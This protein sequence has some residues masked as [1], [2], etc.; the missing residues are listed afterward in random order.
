MTSTEKLQSL[1]I[2]L[3]KKQH[4][5][6][7]CISEYNELKRD[8]ELFELLQNTYTFI[9]KTNKGQLLYHL[10][11]NLS[12]QLC[13]CGKQRKFHK[14][15]KGYFKTCNDKECI[16]KERLQSIKETTIEK[17]G[18]EHTSQ[19][20]STKDKQK[21]TMLDRYGSTHN[22]SG[23][24][25]EK[26]YQNNI[27]KYGVKH[28]LQRGD[29]QEK[30][31]NTMIE[32]FGTLNMLH[33]DKAKKTNLEKYG[34]EN[35][36]KSKEVSDK[37]SVSLKE[38]FINRQIEKLVKWNIIIEKYDPEKQYYHV[39]CNKCKSNI[40]IAG[41]SLNSKLRSDV[42]PCTVCNPYIPSYVSKKEIEVADY[43]K[44][45]GF[46]VQ[47]SVK[48]IV[49]NSE[50]DIYIDDKKIGFEFNGLYWHSEIEK[51]E[52]YHINKTMK[53]LEKDVKIYHIW[54]DSWD[55]KREIVKS[56]IKSI[57]G[58]SEKLDARKCKMKFISS[59]ESK[60]FLDNNHLDGNVNAKVRIGLFYKDELVSVMTFSKA[61]FDRNDDW[62]LL[63][64]ANKLGINVR[65]AASKI[66]KLFI[67]SQSPKNVI[68]Y[69][70]IDWTPS[71]KN[72]VYSTIGFEK[73]DMTAPGVY[74]IV[75]GLRNNRQAY[76]KHKLVEQGEDPD[77]SAIEIMHEKGYYRAWDCGN[78]KFKI[79]I[80]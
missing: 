52:Y 24:I 8:K 9:D 26:T 6:M 25:R 15:D 1:Q 73:I 30:R 3:K 67:N 75:D 66:M 50:L 18:V 23:S 72:S 28:V 10:R 71:E 55:N 56:R 58:I 80:R 16:S 68:S 12:Q 35:A 27:E 46:N 60:Y 69:A 37:V 7:N 45:L 54:E 47:T 11:D 31:T 40:A 29:S 36:I 74:W 64:F 49:K 22:F 4:V 32:K 77:L 13:L 53:Y 57:L 34:F 63:R 5:N 20:Q 42:D 62:E 76:M 33:S 19:L 78:W 21:E 38:T 65:G 39:N 2:S 48:T 44:S 79:H 17:Y 70:K 51:E 43:I 41:A 14:Y 61:R 59:E